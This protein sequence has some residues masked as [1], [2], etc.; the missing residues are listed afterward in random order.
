MHSLKICVYTYYIEK[1]EQRNSTKLEGEYGER[2]AMKRN[3]KE[4]E[5]E[6]GEEKKKGVTYI[7]Y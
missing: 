6:K 2:N 3:M 5:E 1:A 4:D 7:N